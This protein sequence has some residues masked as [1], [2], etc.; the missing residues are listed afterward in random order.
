MPLI[1]REDAQQDEFSMKLGISKRGSGQRTS[2]NCLRLQ[3]GDEEKLA[4]VMVTLEPLLPVGPA[5][6]F[7][8]PGQALIWHTAAKRRENRLNDR[9]G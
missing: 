6:V 4:V 5:F 3:F 8:Q 2:H 7:R 9:I 1:A